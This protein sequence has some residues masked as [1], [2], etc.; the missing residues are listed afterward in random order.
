MVL[1]EPTANLD[2][3]NA[4]KVMNTL[5]QLAVQ[6]KSVVLSTHNPQ[7]A[8]GVNASVCMLKD[9][10]VLAL[11]PARQVVTSDHL[12]RLYGLPILVS[13]TASGHMAVVPHAL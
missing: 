9:R 2:F 3:A 1:D 13:P 4:A 6:G 8:L 10:S 11:G 12:T 7:D 5:Q